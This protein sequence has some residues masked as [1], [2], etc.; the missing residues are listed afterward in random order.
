MQT[1]IRAKKGVGDSEFEKSG[2]GGG[3]WSKQMGGRA[4]GQGKTLS[5]FY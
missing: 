1:L 5:W 4:M 2:G 3:F